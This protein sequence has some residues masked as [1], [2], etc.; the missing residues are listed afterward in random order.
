MLLVMCGGRLARD[1]IHLD[2]AGNEELLLVRLMVGTA[3]VRN[4][5][6][7]TCRSHHAVLEGLRGHTIL[8][9]L[10]VRH[11]RGGHLRL[12]MVVLVQ[13]VNVQAAA[14]L[15]HID[16]VSV[17]LDLD[18]LRTVTLLRVELA[19]IHL[20]DVYYFALRVLP[21]RVVRG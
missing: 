18:C 2:G 20:F 4:A 13:L 21:A 12:L 11:T 17:T 3:V 7:A 15:V 1:H 5:C 9:R 6:L 16:G 8:R 10:V 14:A 19:P